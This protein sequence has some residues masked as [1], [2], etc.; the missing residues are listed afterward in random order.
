M[1]ARLLAGALIAGTL[2]LWASASHAHSVKAQPTEAVHAAF[3]IIETT[4]VTNGDRAVFS[5]RVRGDAGSEKPTSTAS[6]RA[7]MSTPMSGR[8]P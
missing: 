8:Y 6:S 3:D 2:S 7:P 4:I 1:T 5:T